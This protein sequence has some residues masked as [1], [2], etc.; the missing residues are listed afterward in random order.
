MFHCG[1][2]WAKKTHPRIWWDWFDLDTGST[3][4]SHIYS[5]THRSFLFWVYWANRTLDLRMLASSS[6]RNLK[7]D[8]Q[9][10]LGLFQKLGNWS[11]L[12]IQMHFRSHIMNLRGLS[13]KRQEY[14]PGQ[15]SAIRGYWANIMSAAFM[16]VRPMCEDIQY[17]IHCLW[18][19]L[20][21]TRNFS[22]TVFGDNYDLPRPISS[23]ETY[24]TRAL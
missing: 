10:S 4:D 17:L 21:S 3:S 14:S 5:K 12:M 16:L 13:Y 24:L 19:K 9:L 22:S 23:C 18:L 2:K 15:R 8:I 11:L 1:L 6:L 7:R 20:A